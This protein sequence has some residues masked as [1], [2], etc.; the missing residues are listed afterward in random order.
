MDTIDTIRDYGEM[1]VCMLST[2]DD[3][4]V[5]GCAD[6]RI[7]VGRTPL[8]NGKDLVQAVPCRCEC[9]DNASYDP[10][11]LSYAVKEGRTQEDEIL[12]IR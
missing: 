2:C 6:G 8:S 4:P 12:E 5:F 7:T 3:C 9:H 11:A 10:N 1:G